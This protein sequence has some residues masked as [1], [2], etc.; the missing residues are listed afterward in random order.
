M[1]NFLF[2]LGRSPGQIPMYVMKEKIVIEREIVASP[3]AA[4]RGL[5]EARAIV[6]KIG[7]R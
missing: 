4:R 6:N 1:I 7:R 3:E 5:D 2:D